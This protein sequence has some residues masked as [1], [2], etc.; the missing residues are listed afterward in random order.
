MSPL[1]RGWD[2]AT[3]VADLRLVRALIRLFL[4]AVAEPFMG[5]GIGLLERALARDSK[6]SSDPEPSFS[7]CIGSGWGDFGPCFLAAERVTGA[8]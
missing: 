3:A 8:K 4:L 6:L 7:S 2:F 1:V 5:C